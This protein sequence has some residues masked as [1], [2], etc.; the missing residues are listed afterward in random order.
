MPCL[1]FWGEQALP[2]VPEST[3][4]L[5]VEGTG[6]PAASAEF[7]QM[8]FQGRLGLLL[9]FPCPSTPSVSFSLPS[10][11][12]SGAQALSGSPGQVVTVAGWGRKSWLP[13]VHLWLAFDNLQGSDL[14]PQ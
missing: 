13:A 10:T 8:L 2:I 4:L 6:S 3:G 12:T 9:T 1:L 14:C 7:G 11:H 5:S